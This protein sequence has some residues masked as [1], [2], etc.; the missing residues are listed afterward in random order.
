PD[1]KIIAT[2]SVDKT[3]KLWDLETGE[4]IKT[5]SDHSQHINSVSFNANGKVLVSAAEDTTIKLWNVEEGK[6]IRT[7][8]GSNAGVNS[9]LFSAEN[10]IISG[11]AANDNKVR[12]WQQ[13]N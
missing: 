12:I 5:L 13:S 10:Q 9:V 4:L 3:I 1:N 8:S 11:S 6:V 2:G 7:L